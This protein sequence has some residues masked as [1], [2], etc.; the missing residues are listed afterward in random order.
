MDGYGGDMSEIP[1]LLWSKVVD[2]GV[3]ESSS[4]HSWGC[5]AIFP[6]DLAS[7]AIWTSKYILEELIQ[8]SLVSL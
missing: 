4:S 5:L 1:L 6:L 7:Q 2:F 3:L 8:L